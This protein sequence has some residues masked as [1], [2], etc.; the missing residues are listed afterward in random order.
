MSE[1][2]NI[3]VTCI[4]CRKPIE[5]PQR[6]SVRLG[7]GQEVHAECYKQWQDLHSKRV[8]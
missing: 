7:T 2:K 8:N 4:V 5:A 3:P 6:P 1:S